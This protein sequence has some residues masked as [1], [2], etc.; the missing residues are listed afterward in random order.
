MPTIPGLSIDE[1]NE[2]YWA[3]YWLP[4]CPNLPAG[5]DLSFFNIAVNGG[6]SEGH[7]TV[8]AGTGGVDRPA[9]SSLS[10]MRRTG[11]LSIYR[12]SGC[13]RRRV[14]YSAITLRILE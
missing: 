4:Q 5:L 12:S 9:D 11:F 13:A 2:I 7:A 3:E 8:T 10:C 1:Q 6:P 14:C